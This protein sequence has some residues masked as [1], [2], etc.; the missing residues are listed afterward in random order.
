MKNKKIATITAVLF[1]IIVLASLPI[2]AQVSVLSILEKELTRSMQNLQMEKQ[3]K[4]YFISYT[5]LDTSY[6][7][8][9]ATLGSLTE[10]TEDRTRTLD[11]DV[12]VGSYK[13]DNTGLK[14]G[15]G[16]SV[17]DYTDKYFYDRMVAPMDDNEDALRH[18]LWQ[19]T[20]YRYKSAM[21]DYLKKKGEGIYEAP[22]EDEKD[23][24]AFSK[25]EPVTEVEK[26]VAFSVNKNLW[27]EKIKKYSA[28]FS[29]APQI[30]SSSIYYFASAQNRYYI[31]SEGTKVQDGMPFYM[32]KAEAFTRTKD[33]VPVFSFRR[34]YA[35]DEN[36]LP[37]EEKFKSE[38]RGL[39]SEVQS[40][41]DAKEMESYT[42]PVLLAP[43][44][45]AMFIHQ[46]LGHSLEGDKSKKDSG[47]EAGTKVLPEFLSLYDDPAQIKFEGV[48]LLGYYM[49][50]DEGVKAQKVSL[51]ENGIVKNYVMSRKPIKGFPKSNGHGRAQEW[52][53][54]TARLA[55][56]FVTASKTF[57]VDELKKQ[58]I[59]Q[60]KKQNKEYGL[61]I[62]SALSREE[63]HTL[64][65]GTVDE[66]DDTRSLDFIPVVA[67][68]VF[69]KDG[70][71]Q[72]VRGV[73]LVA[74]SPKTLVMR[75][76]AAGNDAKVYNGICSQSDGS[77]Y[78]ATVS[79][80][81]LISEMEAKK[82]KGGKRRP[83]ILPA[84]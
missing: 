38:I 4:P 46:L 7:R 53:K 75:I 2:F 26:S 61:Y 31:N 28:L 58:L 21:Q 33:G 41:M 9:R 55:N 54:I 29:D 14:P 36:A 1:I 47:Y 72:Q 3:E 82:F 79:P 27:E 16:D 43:E 24:D 65:P 22:D 37:D 45:A 10:S 59:A 6:V 51:V 52:G 5:M 83:P 20:D 50:D 64:Y 15:E 34:F 67:Y 74:S 57:S 13:M 56:S 25:E 42:G 35:L 48:P 60:A 73:K 78:T 81:L 77:V 69:V 30:L 71:M 84:P 11:D 62:M 76:V 32:L 12:R 18:R 63:S 70:K 49:V 80:S 19:Q 68:K 40:I 44:P 8:I 66:D 23:V 39:A 17:P